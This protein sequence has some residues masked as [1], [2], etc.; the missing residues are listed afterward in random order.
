MVAVACGR[1]S[2][3]IPMLSLDVQAHLHAGT[4][5]IPTHAR[6][7]SHN[8]GAGLGGQ[9]AIARY[10]CVAVSTGQFDST[11]MVD[12]ASESSNLHF[13]WSG[14]SMLLLRDPSLSTIKPS[15]GTA[16]L[17]A[18]PPRPQRPYR[19]V[20]TDIGAGIQITLRNGRSAGAESSS[21]HASDNF[22]SNLPSIA[23]KLT[24]APIRIS[25]TLPVWTAVVS[26]LQSVLSFDQLVDAADPSTN[27]GGGTGG[28]GSGEASV[29]ASSNGAPVDGNTGGG[30][31]GGGAPS[32]DGATAAGASSPRATGD[33]DG[34]GSPTDHAAKTAAVHPLRRGMRL[35]AAI[36]A[37]ISS[38][39]ANRAAVGG[40]SRSES[41]SGSGNGQQH[42]KTVA[43]QKAAMTAQRQ[44]ASARA[45]EA[46][47]L[48]ADYVR[49][50]Q[51]CVLR[52][53]IARCASRTFALLFRAQEL[54]GCMYVVAWTGDSHST[55]TQLDIAWLRGCVVRCGVMAIAQVLPLRTCVRVRGDL[56][57]SARRTPSAGRGR[58]GETT[59]G[60]STPCYFVVVIR[61]RDIFDRLR[62]AEH[63]ESVRLA[64]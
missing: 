17:G 39:A 60:G 18:P 2:A 5:I 32:T 25:G 33:A 30:G 49:A 35:P 45:V 63:D 8:V 51:R 59:D 11:A 22:V 52:R 36:V 28:T 37:G 43:E 27:S 56:G 61:R 57:H 42:V 34:S 9:Q 24:L 12:V 15:D 20:A 7:Q 64:D 6:Q 10:P 54:N 4:V 16:K 13:K 40:A 31:G 21:R 53:S 48:H 46:T 55:A 3:D 19:V 29:S 38:N 26:T 14:A 58:G 1:Y 41:E 62:S 44:A 50:L 23:A 47:K